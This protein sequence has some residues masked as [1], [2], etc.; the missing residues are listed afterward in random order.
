MICKQAVRTQEEV[1]FRN[2]S[3]GG[4]KKV[5]PSV[6]VKLFSLLKQ[7]LVTKNK[8]THRSHK[9]PDTHGDMSRADRSGMAAAQFAACLSNRV[10]SYCIVF[11]FFFSLL[12]YVNFFL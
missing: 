5:P 6:T 2:G 7:T 11:H 1:S 8:V 4:K 3:G 9:H 12:I 10:G